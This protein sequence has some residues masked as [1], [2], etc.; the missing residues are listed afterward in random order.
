VETFVIRIWAPAERDDAPH[1]HRLR[2]V[3]EHIGCG[4]RD[5]FRGEGELLAFL[6]ADHRLLK[7]VEE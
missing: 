3:V 6:Y 4:E 7:E 5:T 2:G 1:P